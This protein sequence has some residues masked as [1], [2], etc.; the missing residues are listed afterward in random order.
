MNDCTDILSSPPT[1]DRSSPLPLWAQVLDDLRLRL[2][3]GQFSERFP[4]DHELV[5]AYG[6]SRQTAR[7]AVRRLTDAGLLERERGRS[8]RVREFRQ[9]GGSL[10]SLFEQVEAQGAEQRSIVRAATRVTDAAAA[11][12]LALGPRARLVHIERLR[13]ADGAPL[14]LDRTWLPEELGAPLLDADL[15]HTGIYAELFRSAGVEVD[16]AEEHIAPVVPPAPDRRLL[17]LPAR[18]AAFSIDRLT[19]AQGR[20]VEWRQSLVRG[21][22]YTITLALTRSPA[23]QTVPWSPTAPG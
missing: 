14:A 3:R 11:R 2:D 6:V 20:A 10:E 1:V 12:R 5:A 8:T 21:D 9:I 13:L 7:D 23:T 19:R 15:S 17:R 16:S 22:R 18:Q 4:T